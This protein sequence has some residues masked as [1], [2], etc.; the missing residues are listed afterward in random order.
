MGFFASELL[1]QGT[2]D[3][4]KAKIMHEKGFSF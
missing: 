4:K 3:Q 1:K 2:F